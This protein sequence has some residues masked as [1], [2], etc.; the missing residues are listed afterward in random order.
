MRNCTASLIAAFCAIFALTSCSSSKTAEEHEFV[1]LGLS[2]KWA[3]CNMGAQ[4]PEQYGDYFGWGMTTPLP[5]P[6]Y[7][8]TWAD[9]FKGIGGTGTKMEDCGTELDPLRDYVLHNKGIEKTE[10][11]AANVLWGDGWRMP[12]IDEI[13]ELLNE[14]D[15]KW[16]AE[17]KGYLVV[18]RKNGNSIFFPVGGGRDGAITRNE[19]NIGCIWASTPNEGIPNYARFLFYYSAGRDWAGGNRFYGCNIRPVKD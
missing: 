14:C 19:G 9:Y 5:A 18:S 7:E 17:K 8:W 12:T 6:P 15:W 13:R 10:Y 1:D 4:T 16:D 11:D 2:V 3:T